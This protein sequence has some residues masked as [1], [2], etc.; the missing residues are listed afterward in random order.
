MVLALSVAHGT[1]MSDNIAEPVFP[2]NTTSDCAPCREF[3]RINS[4]I[5]D[6]D[7]PKREA[8]AEVSVTLREIDE[9]YRQAGTDAGSLARSVFPLKGYTV[10]AVGRG[11]NHG[12]LQAGYSYFDGN[13]HGGHPSLD[14]FIRDR[15]R[16]ERDD[17]TGSYVAVL[18]VTGGVVVA[19][20]IGWR[21]GSPLRG[22]NYVWMY[23][24]A[25][26]RLYYYAHLRDVSA[27]LGTIVKPG[28]TI[29]FVGRTGTNAHAHRSP[30][31]LHLT[32]LSTATGSL[33]P[34]NLY[35]ELATATTVR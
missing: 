19:R 35:Q 13:R 18:A 15:D 26:R 14:I 29:G 23:D 25:A 28:D 34:V 17:L 21:E 7:L 8:K 27:S 1:A 31:H 4:M 5:R 2:A 6:G 9:W 20:E 11:R 30:T 22:G 24:P 32:C 12:Y 33:R 16:D 3:D 10:T